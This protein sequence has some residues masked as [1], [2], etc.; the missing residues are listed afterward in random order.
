MWATTSTV[1]AIHEM[2]HTVRISRNR[3]NPAQ[4]RERIPMALGQT[5]TAR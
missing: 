1:K 2:R 4:R 3:R 5:A